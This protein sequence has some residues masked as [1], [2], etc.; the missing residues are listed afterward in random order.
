MRTP[1]GSAK[2]PAALTRTGVFHYQQADGSTRREYRPDATVFDTSSLKSYETAV[3]VEGHPAMV[4]ASN[5]KQHA[6]GDVR[7][8]KRDGKFVAAN[9][10]IRDKAT[11][12]KIESG[13]LAEVSCGYD[14]M[15]EIKSGVTD[16]GE[17]YDAIQ[18]GVTINHVG[19]GPR[20]WA[21]AGNDAKLRLDGTVARVDG[22]GNPEGGRKPP[23]MAGEND[24]D[25]KP[26]KVT[27]DLEARLDALTTDFGSLRS[28]L[29]ETKKALDTVTAERDALKARAD[30]AEKKIAPDQIDAAVKQRIAVY[31]GA[32]ALHGKDV[33]L[34]GSER[35]VMIQAIRAR[36]EKFDANGKSD[37][38]VTARFDFEVATIKKSHDSLGALNAGSSGGRFDGK[39]QN[40]GAQSTGDTE[41]DD[42]IARF[43]ARDDVLTAR[44]QAA[45]L[46]MAAEQA[47]ADAVLARHTGKAA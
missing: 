29:T 16:S 14:C 38:Y 27:K 46:G 42:L 11:L 3:V 25:A 13:D 1:Q 22:D 8:V 2:I 32:R 31:D 41:L 24:P 23:S 36:D 15:L 26:S 19:L 18:H 43:D 21:R 10:V 35:D 5:W 20:D 9:L 4:D 40:L 30:A 12:D 37:D 7:D 17:R 34:K 47:A 28:T 6:V 44:M 33:E 45:P 39:N